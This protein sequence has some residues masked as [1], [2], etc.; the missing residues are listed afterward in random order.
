MKKI[1]IGVLAFTSLTSFATAVGLPSEDPI[2]KNLRDRFIQGRAPEESELLGKYFRCTEM[3]AQMKDFRKIEHSELLWFSKF[4][5]FLVAYQEESKMNGK[6]FV[7][8]GSELIG[9]TSSPQYMSYRMDADDNLIGEW[10]DM[11]FDAVSL[12]PVATGV[13]SNQIVAS[14]KICIQ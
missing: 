7:N 11:R 3:V 13:P 9:S 5:G 6:Y 1:V 4:D 12:D 8:N 14:Y 10:T 2:V